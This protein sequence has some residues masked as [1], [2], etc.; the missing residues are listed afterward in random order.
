MADPG[1]PVRRGMAA[2]PGASGGRTAATSIHPVRLAAGQLSGTVSGFAAAVNPAHELEVKKVLQRE[3][4]FVVTCGHELSDLLNFLV[5]A[6]TALLNA[7]I[8]PRMVK[9]FKELD[10]VL[11]RMGIP[12][13]ATI[14]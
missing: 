7:G 5:R 6:R 14:E 2:D 12:T 10:F 9:F 8:I 4:G 13:L 1:G 3:T 11:D